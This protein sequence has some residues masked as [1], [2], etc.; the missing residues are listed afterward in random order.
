MLKC[1]TILLKTHAAKQAAWVFPLLLLF[2]FHISVAIAE[3]GIK[4]AFD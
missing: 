1:K 3:T 4:F 2:Y